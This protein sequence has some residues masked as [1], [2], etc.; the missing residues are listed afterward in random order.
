MKR[1][2]RVFALAAVMAAGFCAAG[3][4]RAQDGEKD[5]VVATV[6]NEKIMFSEI[7]KAAQG[8]NKFLKENFDN[9]RGWRLDFIRQYVARYALT[10]KALKEGLDKDKDVQYAMEQSKR[11]ILSDK[12]LSDRLKKA[13]FTPDDIRKYYE[14]NKL[15]FGTPEKVKISYIKKGKKDEA[16]KIFARLNK[17]EDFVK[18]GRKEIVKL[19][20]W[21]TA[22][23]LPEIPELFNIDGASL[24]GIVSLGVGQCSGVITIPEGLARK[25]TYF[26][27]RVDA[28]E[29]AKERP[30]GE[31][32]GQVELEYA[33]ILRNKIV[34]E[35]ILGTF[36]EEKVV[37]NEGQIK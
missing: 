24:A 28:K 1:V 16:D 23:A 30:F 2:L 18:V 6:G 8:L 5:Y 4:A 22:G 9:H 36:K 37:I 11:T 3:T 19:D 17:G 34:N 21:V 15:H 7:E 31:V 27:F 35:V 26:I 13:E 33:G 14:D 32:K 25:E 10:K 12:L 20:K 29:P